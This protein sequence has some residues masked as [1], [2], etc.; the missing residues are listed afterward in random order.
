[1]T[2][3]LLDV[4]DIL[5]GFFITLFEEYPFMWEIIMA[6]I[7]GMFTGIVAIRIYL[8][9]KRMEHRGNTHD[10]ADTLYCEVKRIVDS[11][12]YKDS[13]FRP[14]RKKSFFM[15]FDI[16][17]GLLSSGNIKYISN[18]LRDSLYEFYRMADTKVESLMDP[19][20]CYDI[21]IKLENTIQKNLSFTERFVNMCGNIGDKLHFRNPF[22]SA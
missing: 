16:Y 4:F 19:V 9:Q 5:M 7:G 13:T 8:W 2:A 18:D 11:I 20:L 12:I 15:D 3:V 22:Q 6:A 10:V 17:R 1:M 21:C 14:K